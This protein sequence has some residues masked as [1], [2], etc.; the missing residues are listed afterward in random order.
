MFVIIPLT[1][2][3]KTN[4]DFAVNLGKIEGLPDNESWA[5]LDNIR[6]VD[7]RRINSIEQAPGGKISVIDN[8]DIM[9]KIKDKLIEKFVS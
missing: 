2:T 1:K 8:A 7:I 3:V 6:A 5:V 4:N 9:K